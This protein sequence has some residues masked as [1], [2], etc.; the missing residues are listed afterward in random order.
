MKKK[1][2]LFGIIIVI[3]AMVA[4]RMYRKYDR[5]QRLDKQRKQ[6]IEWSLKMSKQRDSIL[7]IK[8]DSIRKANFKSRLDSMRE[9][10]EKKLNN[11]KKLMK[12]LENK[13]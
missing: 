12:D 5:Q 1:G 9:V 2:S 8:Q 3:V 7:R 10:N 6:Q 4:I 11:I 13:Q